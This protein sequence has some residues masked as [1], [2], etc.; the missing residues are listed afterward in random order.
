M[1]AAV[2]DTNI[3]LRIVTNDI[4]Q[5]KTEALKV[6]ASFTEQ[7]VL[8][9]EAV[10]AEVTYVLGSKKH[11]SF[12]RRQVLQALENILEMPQLRYDIKL[13]DYFIQTYHETDFDAVDCLALAYVKAGQAQKLLS[14]DTALLHA[15]S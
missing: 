3:L 9:P 12:K 6:L 14:F 5:K 4:P 10:L 8:L 1:L 13:M 2:I 7:A 15:L 11:Y